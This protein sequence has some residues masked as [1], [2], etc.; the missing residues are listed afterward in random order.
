[1]R[2]QAAIESSDSESFDAYVA[3]YQAALKPPRQS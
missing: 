3:R 2:E 1:M